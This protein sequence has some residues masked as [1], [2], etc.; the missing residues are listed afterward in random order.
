M[1]SCKRI[2]TALQ[3]FT[4]SSSCSRLEKKSRKTIKKLRIHWETVGRGWPLNDQTLLQTSSSVL[5]PSPSLSSL[6]L[7]YTSKESRVMGSITVGMRS[8]QFLFYTFPSRLTL[9]TIPLPTH[10]TESW[11]LLLM[12]FLSVRPKRICRSLKGSSCS[13]LIAITAAEVTMASA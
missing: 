9:L 6:S 11:G 4:V 3:W 10:P 7:I 5:L 8:S 12:P 1:I 2:R 13:G